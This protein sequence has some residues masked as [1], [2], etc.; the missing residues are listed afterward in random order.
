MEEN[1]TNSQDF[2]FKFTSFVGKTGVLFSILLLPPIFK[3][4]LSVSSLVLKEEARLWAGSLMFLILSLLFIFFAKKIKVKYSLILFVINLLIFTETLTRVFVNV[5]FDDQEKLDLGLLAN[6]TY[7]EFSLFKGHPF[8]AYAGQPPIEYIEGQKL[9]KTTAFNSMGFV[10]NEFEYSKPKNIIRVACIGG[11]TTE[12]GYPAIT[13]Y[14]LNSLFKDTLRFEVLNF[15]VS[16]WTS[17]N[18]LINF[19]L[20]V[21]DFNPDFVIIH[22]GWNEGKVRNTPKELFRNDYSHA[23]TYFH[24]PEIIDKIP[25]RLSVLYRI[26]KN[27]FTH[28]PDWMFLG[29]AT[30][31]KNREQTA[32]TYERKEELIPFRRNIETI[33]SLCMLSNTK[34]VLSTQPFSLTKKDYTSIT[35]EQANS[36]MR[37][38]YYKYNK[39]ILFLDLDS[40][41]TG[42]MN[43]LFVDLAHMNNQGIFYKGSE[44]ARIIGNEILKSPSIKSQPPYELES[45]PYYKYADKYSSSYTKNK[46]GED[47][48]VYSDAL[49]NDAFTFYNKNKTPLSNQFNYYFQEY[50][51]KSNK[52]WFDKIKQQAKEQGVS[53]NEMLKKNILYITNQHIH[54][55]N[56]FSE[57]E[58]QVEKIRANKEWFEN[59]QKEAEIRGISV[60]SM[61]VRAARFTINE[62]NKK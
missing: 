1:K 55:D 32:Q 27:K 31:L 24:E 53:E 26:L 2:E 21:R 4:T 3:S 47:L 43:D 22:H 42:K 19:V 20:N 15:G 50:K 51:I 40:A 49:K 12:R 5:S 56:N 61:L 16:G 54:E 59:I 41:V 33:I 38:L 36:I 7:D 39:E 35:I 37:D 52:E 48:L 44:F 9:K 28:T 45:I 34:V 25:L 62:K 29:D 11:S 18:S 14:Q 13:E 8:L 17:A 60:D 10:G 58:I 57:V 46:S 23:L 6:K 30:T